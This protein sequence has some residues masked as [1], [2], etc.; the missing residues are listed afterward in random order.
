MI[1]WAF[2]QLIGMKKV[3]Y[4]GDRSPSEIVRQAIWLYLRFSLSFR[5]VEDFL[6]ER[7]IT[8]S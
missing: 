3:S 7:G 5:N 1:F 2:T 4:N 6:S 8:V